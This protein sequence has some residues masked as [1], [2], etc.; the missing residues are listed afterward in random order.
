MKK[1][2]ESPSLEIVGGETNNTENEGEGGNRYSLP[3]GLCKE[4]GIDTTGMRPREAWKALES[5]TGKTKEQFE[6][7]H[8]GKTAKDSKEG[9]DNN[10]SQGIDKNNE[11]EYNKAKREKAIN[12]MLNSD[13]IKVSKTLTKET[14]KKNLSCGTEEMQETTATAF[15]NDS[16]VYEHKGLEA[17][18]Y[19]PASNRVTFNEADDNYD[20]D[21][22]YH[23]SWHAIDRNY[24]QSVSKAGFPRCLSEAYL[25]NDGKTFS[26][27]LSED[28][29]AVNWKEIKREIAEEK[30]TLLDEIEGYT[31]EERREIEEAYS[32]KLNE[33]IL[34]VPLNLG[35]EKALDIAK[36]KIENT[37]ESQEYAELKKAEKDKLRK[38]KGKWA[39]LSDVYSGYTKGRTDLIGY[40]HKLSYWM[41]NAIMR[42]YGDPRWAEE[43]CRMKRAGEA[44][45]EIASAKAVN[46]ESYENLKKYLPNVVA[47]FEEIFE[48]IKDGRIKSIVKK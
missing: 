16:Y 13:R 14:I 45:A 38:F 37:K 17:S 46:P 4:A 40:G 20:G 27:K 15:N 41:G 26:D 24:A 32:K 48:K 30:N 3:Y 11:A 7:E 34:H 2:Y 18:A 1:K 5:K 47:G 44:F 28:A 33:A 36:R 6:K 23:E 19:V 22:F 21:T 10:S 12:E 43:T 42:R 39:D 25:L 31:K 9:S 29:S 35:N 8:W